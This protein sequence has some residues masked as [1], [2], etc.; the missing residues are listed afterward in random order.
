MVVLTA[1]VSKCATSSQLIVFHVKWY[2]LA[3]YLM[4]NVK[5]LMTAVPFF[6]DVDKVAAHKI[7]L[8]NSKPSAYPLPV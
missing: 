2:L 5:I 1:M 3:L 6:K 8:S 7:Y 4:S